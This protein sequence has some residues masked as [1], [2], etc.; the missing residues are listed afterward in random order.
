MNE[1]QDPNQ[2]KTIHDT[3]IIFLPMY[4][5]RLPEEMLFRKDIHFRIVYKKCIFEFLEIHSLTDQVDDRS[6]VG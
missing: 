5:T 3:G 4:L 6:I 2:V 1:D